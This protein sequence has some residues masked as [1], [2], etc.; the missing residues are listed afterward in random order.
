MPRAVMYNK[1]TPVADIEIDN[2]EVKKIHDCMNVP[3]L[4]ISLQKEPPSPQTLTEWLE[5]RRIPK[6]REG[7]KQ[8]REK[9]P[10]FEAYRH[11]FSLGDQYW[12]RY[13]TE[14]TWESLNFFTN[15]Y[16]EDVGRL[17]FTPW[18]VEL[19]TAFTE[20]PDLMTN[21]ALRKR[22]KQDAD[23]TS[24]LIKAGSRRLNQEPISEVLA[25]MLLKR[26]DV[27]PFVEYELVVEGMRLCSKCKNF[28]TAETEFVPAIHVY[29][30]KLRKKGETVYTHL[31]RMCDLYEVDGAKDFID[32]MI[33]VDRILGNKDRHLG[34]FGFIRD[35]NTLKILG[36]APLFD[37]GY[38]FVQNQG[39]QR[40]PVFEE[41]EGLEA[42]KGL[43]P[44]I[45]ID[46]F[47]DHKDM[48]SLIDVYPEISSGEK[49]VIKEKILHA[50]K[51]VTGMT[52]KMVRGIGKK[53]KGREAR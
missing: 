10:G 37:S 53:E 47:L 52:K 24:W 27:I 26:L 32:C 34:N 17:F 13:S 46:A 18:E 42:L 20:T 21:G 11:M 7:L 45:N 39:E 31:L 16:S 44:H 14:E 43:L 51:E 49:Q 28:V 23:G 40:M 9:F 15:R 25:T 1:N 50:E 5:K 41:E 19:D 12:F 33:A 36:F 48:F 8:A 3:Y 30:T 38:A 2:C 29:Q 4:P 22:W 35:V 6:S